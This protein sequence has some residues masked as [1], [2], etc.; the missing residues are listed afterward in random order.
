[1]FYGKRFNPYAAAA[2]QTDLL[3]NLL[4]AADIERKAEDLSVNKK[5]NDEWL[6]KT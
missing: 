6:S 2:G 3:E 5:R 1:M 4:K